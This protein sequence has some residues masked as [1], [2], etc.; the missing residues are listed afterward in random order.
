MKKNS[1]IIGTYIL[2]RILLSSNNKNESTIYFEK[3]Y[4]IWFKEGLW[5]EFIE[6]HLDYYSEQK[7]ITYVRKW[8]E[9]YGSYWEI[10]FNYNDL[11]TY[12][13]NESAIDINNELINIDKSL[14]DKENAIK[15]LIGFSPSKLE[16]EIADTK[17]K[18]DSIKN[19]SKT[20]EILRPI[21]E[22]IDIL[23]NY[24]NEMHSLNNSYITIYKNLINPVKEESV[25]GVKA[26]TTWAIIGI[27]VT[28]LI[29]ILITYFMNKSSL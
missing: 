7:L 19:L 16:I 8:E 29:S 17:S 13:N 14:K 22:K 9:D 2:G 11:I 4:K 12:Y 3:G 1:K 26:T 18:L 28:T 23:S 24:L 10:K 5:V 25:K 21:V 20:N 27:I 15:E 6:L